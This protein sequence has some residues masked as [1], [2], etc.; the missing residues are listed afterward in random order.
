MNKWNGL[1]GLFLVLLFIA[2]EAN[3]SF[4]TTAQQISL[5]DP[6]HPA[7]GTIYYVANDGDNNANGQTPGTAWQTLEH[8][9]DQTFQPGDSILFRRGDTW[10]DTLYIT[11]S[12]T[13]DAW[14]TFGAYGTGAKPRLL[15]SE[16]ATGW[17]QVATNIWR[18]ATPLDNPY[19]GGY[20]YGEVYFEALDSSTIWGE[21]Q[22]YNAS[23]TNLTKEFD[24]SWHADRIYVYAPTNPGTR[25]TS[26]EVP[27]RDSII[28]FPSVDGSYVPDEDYVEYIAIDN[29]ELMYAL[30]HG[31]YPGYNELEA[32]GLRITNNHIGMIGV[33]GGSSAYCI[34]AWHSD[35]LIQGNQIHD[36]GRRGISLNTYTNYTP[37]FTVRNVVIDNNH[38][39]NGY[40]TT[41]PDVSSL[42]GLNHT[43]TNFTISNN[44][45]DESARANGGIHD[46][47]AAGSCTSNVIYISAHDSHY[48]DFTIHHNIIIDATSRAMLLVDM[49]DVNVYHNT[50]YG[51]HPDARP[52]GL[53]LFDN[54]PDVDM[55]NNICHGTLSDD[56][57]GDGRCVLD[58]G[59]SAFTIRNYNLYFQEDDGQPITG[60]EHGVGGWDVHMHEWDS[61]RTDSGF[62]AN[63][64]E[65]ERPLFIDPQNG[66]FNLDANSP[67]IDAGVY[68]PGINDGYQGSAPDLGALE[69]IPSLTLQGTPTN[70]TINLTWA[71]NTTIPTTTT[72][73]F[74]YYTTT[75]NIFTATD[76][77]S[78]TRSYALTGLSNYEWYTVTLSAM[79]DSNVLYS[80]TI[81]AMP[82]DISVHLPAIMKDNN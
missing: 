62:E 14:I 50:V 20:S 38:F 78:A 43:F 13:T 39:A 76:P 24:W 9:N 80:D 51:S 46:G 8:V 28:R 32:H 18:S 73:H 66:D 3:A 35:M 10:R 6:Q 40:H 2:L 25:Y 47:C 37:G 55:R 81:R 68:I 58:Q 49:A 82:T 19:R 4:T 22:D 60:S 11:S 5:H 12:G 30:R 79:L 15:G 54:V 53:I 27:Q 75:T 65:P 71:I 7:A 36:C 23:H 74:N 67:A 16:Q 70:Q 45:F 48:T 26:V 1:G 17:T 57:H 69:F 34:A 77:T 63:S 21:Q 33:K 52:Y 41:G 31:I 61:W 59:S 72:W 56:N 42:S 44:V 64:P 29:L